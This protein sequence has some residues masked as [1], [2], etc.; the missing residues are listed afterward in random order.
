MPTTTP[1][2]KIDQV[3]MF[4][5]DQVEVCLAGDNYDA[6]FEWAQ[7]D[8]IDTERTLIHPF[9]DEKVIEGQATI[10]LEILDACREPLD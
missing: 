2:Q 4:G 3:K 6:S 7:K 9:D 1:V 5:K 10:A 8:S